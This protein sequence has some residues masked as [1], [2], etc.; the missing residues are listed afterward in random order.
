MD[1]NFKVFLETAEI[2]VKNNPTSDKKSNKHPEKKLDTHRAQE[3]PQYQKGGAQDVDSPGTANRVLECSVLES[4]T[5][6]WQPSHAHDGDSHLGETRVPFLAFGTAGLWPL[7]SGPLPGRQFEYS[8]KSHTKATIMEEHFFKAQICHCL[9]TKE[10]SIF[11]L[12][13]QNGACKD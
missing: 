9:C 10:C 5:S 1:P 12:R 2:E 11:S 3:N 8:V 13:F 4:L 6:W 7:A